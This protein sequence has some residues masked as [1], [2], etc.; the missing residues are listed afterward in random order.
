M[1]KIGLVLM[2]LM[3]TFMLFACNF[4]NNSFD[5]YILISK[6][7][8]VILDSNGSEVE[9]KTIIS[10]NEYTIECTIEY[11]ISCDNDGTVFFDVC[12]GISN[13]DTIE[14]TVEI[15]SVDSSK[16]DVEFQ[17]DQISKKQSTTISLLTPSK[18]NEVK[19]AKIS[20]K[21]THSAESE[22]ENSQG[23]IGF[24][25]ND[26][27]SKYRISGDCSDGATFVLYYQNNKE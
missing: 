5:D 18:A 19:S 9:G 1:K 7:D 20:I 24:E 11:S 25:M 8:C 27:T 14:G 6:M 4:G 3:Q 2:A 21:F 10:G 12:F 17:Y 26:K 23:F 22:S 15:P 16:S 13:V